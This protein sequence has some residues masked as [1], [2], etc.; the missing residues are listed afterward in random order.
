MG[1]FED[2]FKILIAAIVALM[3][4]AICAAILMNLS[5]TLNP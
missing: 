3:L 5:A 1:L 4:A 2:P